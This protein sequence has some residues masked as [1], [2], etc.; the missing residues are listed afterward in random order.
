MAG[1]RKASINA[2]HTNLCKFEDSQDNSLAAT[3]GYIE[4]FFA[5][6]VPRITTRHCSNL[7]TPPDDL[8]Y[9]IDPVNDNGDNSYPVLEYEEHWYYGTYL[10]Y[11]F[12]RNQQQCIDYD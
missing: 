7:P 1:E 12:S 11:I 8:K 5:D 4:E 9:P 2:D 6:V 3:I 10:S